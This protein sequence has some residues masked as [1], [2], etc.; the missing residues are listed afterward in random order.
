[1]GSVPRHMTL[2]A[3]KTN[4]RCCSPGDMINVSGILLPQPPEKRRVGGLR[5]SGE[6]VVE[7]QSVTR[8]KTAYESMLVD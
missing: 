5:L 1:M 6:V 8:Q 7:V 4:V 3:R 2:I